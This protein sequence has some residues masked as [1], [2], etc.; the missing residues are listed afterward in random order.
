MTMF[1]SMTIT[2]AALI[3]P[4]SGP[5]SVVNPA[6]TTGKVLAFTPLRI[7]AKRNS[8]HDDQERED[9]GDHEPGRDD[10]DHDPQEDARARPQ[11][12]IMAA[13]SISSGTSTKKPMRSQM[14]N[15]RANET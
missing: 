1:G 7:S 5:M 3:S 8:F 11:P 9:R 10:R 15:G 4:Y 12:S 13:S 6:M 2:A 14:V